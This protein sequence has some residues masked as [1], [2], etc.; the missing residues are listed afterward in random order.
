MVS[1]GTSQVRIPSRTADAELRGNRGDRGPLGVQGVDDLGGGDP[2]GIPLRLLR[3][4][5]LVLDVRALA[6]PR[7]MAVTGPGPA[8]R[9]NAWAVRAAAAWIAARWLCRQASTASRR[10]LTRG[11]RAT[12]CT[13]WG[14]S[15]ANAIGV[16]GPPITTDDEDGRMRREPGGHALCRA[17]GQQGNAPMILQIAQDRPIA[18]PTPPRPRIDPKHLWGGDVRRRS[19]PSQPQQDVGTG[20]PLEAGREPGA[21][22]STEGEVEGA[23]VLGVP[24]RPARQRGRHSGQAF[25]KNLA[26]ARRIVTE[27]LPHAALHTHGVDAPRQISDGACIPAEDPRG[28][29]VAERAWDT[30]VGRGHL[31]RDLRS[32][33]IDVPRLQG[34]G[35]SLR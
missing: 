13:A 33:I 32:H 23:E 16:E 15:P 29:H 19:R 10:F 28:L 6:P 21:C 5:P 8:T 11:D 3:L 30:G 25:C 31:Q 1:G 26:W 18:L 7:Y 20:P 4:P 12:T 27:K 9:G 22:L 14:G 2:R 34:Q 35:R 17:L 24:Q